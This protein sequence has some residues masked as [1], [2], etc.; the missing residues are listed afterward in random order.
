MISCSINKWTN[1]DKLKHTST[2]WVLARD[3]ELKDV[4]DRQEYTDDKGK[5]TYR[6]SIT[7]PVNSTYYI[8]AERKFAASPNANHKLPIRK[9]RNTETPIN[10]LILPA[11]IK[12]EQ[13]FVYINETDFKD[14][15]VP[16]FAVHT[17]EFRCTTGGHDSTHWIVMN[18]SKEIIFKSLY[19]K[20][21]K[22][23]IRLDKSQDILN[24]TK[25][26]IMAIHVS[27]NGVESEPGISYIANNQFSFDIEGERDNLLPYQ[28]AS[29][30]ISPA[31]A[32]N[33]I[34]SV[35]LNDQSNLTGKDAYNITPAKGSN[36]IVIPGDM[37][38]YGSKYF[39]DIYCY[40]TS[41]EYL[42]RR[43]PITVRVNDINNSLIN[44]SYFKRIEDQDVISNLDFPNAYVT[45]EMV[46]GQILMPRAGVD[47]LY[48]YNLKTI[49]TMTGSKLSL[50]LGD[51]N[52]GEG[53]SGVGLLSTST[54]NMYIKFL[55]DNILLID[56]YNKDTFPEFMVY[57][58]D[59]VLNTYT[60]LQTCVRKEEKLPIG[61]NNNVFQVSEDVI[62]YLPPGSPTTQGIIYSYTIST[63]GYD[64]YTHGLGDSKEYQLIGFIPGETNNLKICSDDVTFEAK[65]NTP[66][67]K[68]DVDLKLEEIDGDSSEDLSDGLYTVLGHDKNYEAN[69]YLY[70][71]NGILRNELI[72]DDYRDLQIGVV[73]S[74]DFIGR[75]SFC[76]FLPEKQRGTASGTSPGILRCRS[77]CGMPVA[78]K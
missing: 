24:R 69:V 75:Y 68:A 1:D 41:G 43:Y 2:V 3:P 61:Y 9:V 22:T 36:N 17:S 78:C 66:D 60:L 63:N 12:I 53:V 48:K 7:V 42:Q 4:I 65:I 20:F 47:K 62:W 27:D 29:L 38:T 59:P 64:S 76:F 13:P 32:R 73:L 74:I 37:L 6:S 23:S 28:D 25:V 8:Q 40:S 30:L 56:M 52:L 45:Q 49:A 39:L 18:A 5:T 58:Y 51:N 71:N 72:L 77:G 11:S 26:T 10:N 57:T 54:D 21:N 44:H 46:N 55:N 16:D 14:T 31:S 33:T 67:T 19:D 50:V 35:Y 15:D 34:V 70:D